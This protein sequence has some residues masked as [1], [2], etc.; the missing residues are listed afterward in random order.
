MVDRRP[1][2]GFENSGES[3]WVDGGLGGGRE[4]P[5][6]PTS[7]EVT[8]RV[9]GG[10]GGLGM[11]AV[12]AVVVIGIIGLLAVVSRSSSADGDEATGETRRTLP[13]FFTTTTSTPPPSTTAAA[14]G[15][16]AP[17]VPRTTMIPGQFLLGEPTGLWL[18]YGGADPL[19]RIDLDSAEVIEYGLQAS[20]VLA[21]GEDLVLY[22][23]ESKVSG[24]VLASQPAEQPLGW[25]VG[26]VAPGEDD[27]RLWV[28]DRRRP[29]DP[30]AETSVGFGRWQLFDTGDNRVLERRP[31]D[32]YE[33]LE[34]A[35]QEVD[36]IGGRFEI[37]R[38]GPAFSNRPDGVY[39]YD[40]GQYRRVSDGRVL[41]YGRSTALI[42][43]CAADN[44][45]AYDW[46]DTA[47]GRLSDGP[48][49]AGRVVFA[50][51]LAGDRW[52]HTIDDAGRSEL[53][54]FGS[55]RRFGFGLVRPTVSPDGRW[56][57]VVDEGSVIIIDLSDRQGPVEFETLRIDGGGDLL[58]VERSSTAS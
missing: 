16:A 7:A 21:T 44:P 48:A 11:L 31:G 17:T 33:E 53:L 57:A 43:R 29:A 36:R 42:R 50:E 6:A 3:G 47:T 2:D 24:W 18:F 40:D 41:T 4:F 15:S 10:G 19:Q 52:L 12:V 54:E 46:I 32:L 51:L 49:P 9:S 28:L 35:D 37:L 14:F 13:G 25:Q 56:L 1:G 26:P 27:G 38:P 8:D 55:D 22:Q 34:D 5:G 23:I 58:F 45:C 30:D 39:R 20:P